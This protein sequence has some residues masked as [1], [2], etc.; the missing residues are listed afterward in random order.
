MSSKTFFQDVLTAREELKSIQEEKAQYMATVYSLGGSSD[1]HVH[2]N[3]IKSRTESAAIRLAELCGKLDEQADKYVSI[4][5]QA[6]SLIKRVESLRQRQVLTLR[7]LCGYDWNTVQQ[8][9]GYQDI[10]SAFRVHGWALQAVDLL[11][12]SDDQ[13]VK[14]CQRK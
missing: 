3:E 4:L 7:Y 9:M 8:K 1:I 14:I 5:E 10:K 13:C 6:R 12:Q 2:T 11:L